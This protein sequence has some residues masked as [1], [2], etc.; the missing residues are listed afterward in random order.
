MTIFVKFHTGLVVKPDMNT[1]LMYY[2]LYSISLVCLEHFE[3]FIDFRWQGFR[4]LVVAN[5]RGGTRRTKFLIFAQTV[6][7]ESQFIYFFGRKI[8]LQ[9][10]NQNSARCFILTV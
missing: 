10:L 5:S 7:T 2:I 4:P 8:F 3:V 1:L 6:I 9:D